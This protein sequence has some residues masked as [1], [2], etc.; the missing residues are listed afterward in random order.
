MKLAMRTLS[1]KTN[2][3]I[4]VPVMDNGIKIMPLVK[5]LDFPL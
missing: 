4:I 2:T 3:V 1:V 5:S